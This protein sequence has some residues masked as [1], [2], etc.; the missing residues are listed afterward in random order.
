V[1]TGRKAGV[2]VAVIILIIAIG[3]F[4]LQTGPAKRYVFGKVQA[5][6]AESSGIDLHA[7]SLNYTLGR[8]VFVTMDNAIVR[9]TQA[10][11]LPPVARIDHV[12]LQLALLPLLHGKT[13]IADGS[14]RNP[15]LHVVMTAGGKDNLPSSASQSTT[16]SPSPSNAPAQ[17]SGSSSSFEIQKLGVAGGSLLLEDQQQRLTVELPQFGARV[18][19]ASAGA[20]RVSLTTEAAGQ[21]AYQGRTITVRGVSLE[22][23]LGADSVDLSKVNLGLDGSELNLAGK[24]NDLSNPVLD[25]HADANVDLGTLAQFAGLKQRIAGAAHLQVTATGPSSAPM[26]DITLRGQGL[27]VEEFRAVNISADARYNGASRRLLLTSLDLASS[28]GRLHAAGDL[29]LTPAAGQSELHAQLH[30]LNLQQVTRLL[31][32][33]LQIASTASGNVRAT[34]PGMNFRRAD[35]RAALHLTKLRGRPAK[36]V[37]PLAGDVVAT[38]RDGAITLTIGGRPASP[39]LMGFVQ[40][41][42]LCHPERGR[43]PESKEPRVADAPTQP[44]GV[45]AEQRFRIV[46]AAYR[47]AAAGPAPGISIT[48]GANPG[49]ATSFLFA[50]FQ[51]AGDQAAH[52][53]SSRQALQTLATLLH[54][55]ITLGADN[56]LSGTLKAHIT[57]MRQFLTRLHELQGGQGPL[58]NTTVEGTAD[59][60]A[61]LGG[62]IDAPRANI[63][64]SAPA[65]RVGD[66][67]GVALTLAALYEPAKLT[68]RRADLRWQDESA[69][70]T[71]TVGLKGKRPPLRLDAQITGVKLQSVM[72]GMSKSNAQASGTVSVTAHVRGTTKAPAANLTAVGNGLALY[73]KPLG[74]ITAVVKV[75]NQ[76]AHIQLQAPQFNLTTAATIGIAPPYPAQFTLRAADLDLGMLPVQL[77]G[78]LSGIISADAAGTVELKNP[79]AAQITAQ[80]PKL[81]VNYRGQSIR[82]L[83]PVVARYDNRVLDL[84]PTT[85]VAGAS[86]VQIGGQ[87]P[88]QAG[89]APANMRLAG[90]LDLASLKQFVSSLA[91]AQAGGVVSLNLWLR[92]SL[93]ALE[94][95]G[96]ISLRNGLLRT[97]AMP[98]PVQAANFDAQIG[99]GVIALRELSARFA[100]GTLRA[101]GSIPLALLPASLPIA[102]PPTAAP[103][104]FTA[105]FTGLNLASVPKI[106]SDMKGLVSVHLEAQAP[107]PQL[108]ALSALLRFDQLQLSVSGVPINQQGAATVVVQNGVARVQQF[109]LAGPDTA[110]ELAGTADLSPPHALNLALRGNTNAALASVFTSAIKMTGPTQIQL[111]LTGTMQ[112][113]QAQGFVAMQNG[114]VAMENPNVALSALN[115]RVNLTGNRVQIAQLTGNLNG[116]KLAGSGGFNFGQ[117]GLSNVGLRVNGSDV[118]LDYPDGLRTVSNLVLTFT[119]ERNLYVLGGNVNLQEGSFRRYVNLET[120]VLSYLQGGGPSLTPVQQPGSLLSR[121]RFN[122]P[123]KTQTPLLIE[124]N[125]AKAAVAADLH[126]LGSYYSP[127][128]T[129]RVQLMEAGQLFFNGKTFYIQRGVVNFVNAARIE[130]MVDLSAQTQT[131]GYTITM[132]VTG[133]PGKLTTNLVSDPPLARPDII[134]VLVF[135]QPLQNIRNSEVNVAEQQAFFYIAGGL[136]GAL[137]NQIQSAT[138][139]GEVRVDPSLIAGEATP[140]ARL[141][142]GQKLTRALKVIYSMD[143]IDPNDRIWIGQYD[144]TRHFVTQFTKQSDNSY[145]FDLRHDQAFGGTPLFQAAGLPKRDVGAIHVTGNTGIYDPRQ[146]A[147]KLKLKPG[148]TYDFFKATKGVDRIQ[149][150][151]HKHGYLESQARIS[152]APTVSKV[153]INLEVNAGPAVHFAF[154][155]WN[156]PGSVRRDVRKLWE[157]GVFDVQR[158]TDCANLI[159]TGL[160]KQG[161]VEALVKYYVTTPQPGLKQVSFDIIPGVRYANVRTVFQGAQHIKGEELQEQLKDAHLQNQLLTEPSR[162][163]RQ[164]QTYYQDQGYLTAKVSDPVLRVNRQAGTGEIVVP[165]QEGPLYHVAKVQF[166]G[167]RIFPESKLQSTAAIDVHQVY[168]PEQRNP[169]LMNIQ[170]LYWNDGYQDMMVTLVATPDPQ[171]ASVNL[172]FN[173]SEGKQ[174]I[175][176]K[177]V[178]QGTDRTSPK[179]VRSDIDVKPGQP[180]ANDKLAIARANL[181]STGAYDLVEIKRRP[182]AADPPE[183]SPDQQPVELQVHVHEVRPWRWLYGGYYD[184]DRGPGVISDISNTNS[185]GSARVLGLLTRYDQDFQEARLYFSQPF[186][187]RFPYI[188][189]GAAY[190]VRNLQPAFVDDHLGWQIQQERR[191]RHKWV[192]DY[193][194]QLERARIFNLTSTVIAAGPSSAGP[195]TSP[196]ASI[197]GANA[198]PTPTGGSL[199]GPCPPGSTPTDNPNVPGGCAS[200]FT[201][202]IPPHGS[203]STRIAPVSGT[204]TLD[205]RDD[206]LDATHGELFSQGLAGGFGF[207]ASQQHY[208]KYVGQYYRF[209]P[210]GKPQPEPFKSNIKRPRLVYAGAVRIGLAGGLG[211]QPLIASERFFAGGGTT[212]RGF[213]QYELGPKDPNGLPIGGNAEFIINNEVRFPVKWIFDGAAFSDLGNVYSL[214]SDFRPWDLRKTAG[215][216]VRVHTPYFLIRAD[217]G[218]KLDRRPGESFGAFFFSIGQAF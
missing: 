38:A 39:A 108:N 78:G 68:I 110:L 185:L 16:T 62:T 55:Q 183:L 26:S 63:R 196:S 139:I 186:L 171:T 151:Y 116:G 190:Y 117:G 188:S 69:T 40:N 74:T 203:L 206:V 87:I 100:S 157:Q 86:R 32:S 71:G 149:G 58:V 184:T 79:Q 168:K 128:V 45:P 133:T 122:L 82:A 43:T 8:R 127:A 118:A 140:G 169:A 33:K 200:V 57:D 215:A 147:G 61:I 24:I 175:V 101:N 172:A 138:G 201:T 115:L 176:E 217:Y 14:I 174:S 135:G 202:P 111:A 191:F 91:A 23:V 125:V 36:N 77:P 7:S 194:Y 120:E 187:R 106:P 67:Q 189:T 198:L 178:V 96:T 48:L 163:R 129:G 173:I 132:T 66:L 209:V 153:N 102:V 192:F 105:D 214:V 160:I 167:N 136:G 213:H 53:A 6:L 18:Q 17:Q 131:A 121:L 99:N 56:Q 134:S 52:T 30:S 152:T 3:L 85:I 208:L 44:K 15:H 60:T 75:A 114:A 12:Q 216:G 170:N 83:Q 166:N 46:P 165:I 47:E 35:G 156:V 199:S 119:S 27:R 84:Q 142:V 141:T 22:G 205:T 177:I 10:P 218:I 92:G 50:F 88:L 90:T 103:A 180:A 179:L 124:D 97:A 59:I 204:V 28:A 9:S 2:I 29:A 107:R 95:Q 64:A 126:L 155:G 51:A 212:V 146:L 164:L 13:V 20:K 37:L 80:I 195:N 113:P 211:G 143:L 41:P 4:V 34:W 193:S 11:G 42:C 31:N 19:P 5:S 49:L 159:R 54:G 144:L 162:V 112:A 207:L 21:A 210:L 98:A 109:R 94:P 145:R 89:I 150:D 181:Y 81:D 1:S 25:L 197:P 161:Y 182:L 148:K 76:Q 123:V 137:S 104:R 130:P 70:M 72:A 65:V 73:G 154:E 93:T 158:A